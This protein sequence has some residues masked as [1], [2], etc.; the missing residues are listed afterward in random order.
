MKKLLL[1]MISVILICNSSFAAIPPAAVI[2]AFEQKFPH[3][4]KVTWGKENAT[5]WEAE[6]TLNGSKISANF[7]INGTWV[8]TEKI[9]SASQLPEGVVNAIK[10]KYAG[11]TITEADQTE[12]AKHGTIYEADIRKGKDKKALAFKEDGTPVNE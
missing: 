10:T 5:E 11:W 3:A 1:F 12:S 2:K 7:L 4:A 8:E 9:I 6:F